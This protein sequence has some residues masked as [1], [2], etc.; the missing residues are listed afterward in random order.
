MKSKK[1]NEYLTKMYFEEALRIKEDGR[2]EVSLPW[3]GDHLPLSNNKEIAMKRLGTSTRKLHHENLFTA[4]D[5]MFKE[6]ASLGIIENDP[7][8]SSSRHHEHYL[9]HR[10]VVKQHG[11]TKV[12]PDFDASAR[13]VG[14]PSLNQCLESGPNL[15][16]LTPSLL[17]RFREHKY[18]IVADI[19]K[20]FLQISVRPEDRNF[21]K[22]FWWNGKENVEPKIM[23]HARVFEEL[24]SLKNLS[25]SRCFHPASSGQHGI[26]VHTFCDA[27]QFAY[28]A[29]VFVR[30]ECA[31]VVQVNLLAAK[32]RVASV[33]T[34]T[35]PRLE[36]LAATVG[37]RLCRSVLRQLQW[38]NIKQHY[39]TDSTTVLGW[40]QR[41]ELWSVSTNNRVQEIRKL[42][43]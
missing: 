30:I 33:K 16:E 43:D 12:R 15:L 21:L 17:L 5:D 2:Y 6:W 19:Q 14:S 34:I 3:K 39:W 32:S 25:V 18:N 23:R 31:D 24:G 8:E 38:D 42:T 28:A 1:E 37:A 41:E 7:V 11:T 40:I 36:L 29:A 4:Y 9:P 22:F 26:S 10:P 35:I 27:S 13:Q 20:A